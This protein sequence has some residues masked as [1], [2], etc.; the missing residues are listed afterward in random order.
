MVLTVFEYWGIG[1][2]EDFGQMVFNLIQVGVFGK[3]DTDRIEDFS[4]GYSFEDAFVRPFQPSPVPLPVPGLGWEA[5]SAPAE[6]AS[7]EKI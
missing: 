6:P 2:C 5:G 7:G 3:N 1:R 4:G